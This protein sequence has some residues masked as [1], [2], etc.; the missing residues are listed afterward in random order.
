MCKPASIVDDRQFGQFCNRTCIW[1]QIIFVC[2]IV[3]SRFVNFSATCMSTCQ[4]SRL[5]RKIR[6]QMDGVNW[7]RTHFHD[8]YLNKWTSYKSTK[9]SDKST[10]LSDKS[11]KRSDKST[12]LSGKWGTEIC[13]HRYD[14]KTGSPVSRHVKEPLVLKGKI[15][16]KHRYKF[17][18]LHRLWLRPS[19]KVLVLDDQSVKNMQTSTHQWKTRFMTRSQGGVSIWCWHSIPTLDLFTFIR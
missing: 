15:S 17:A 7:A 16:A 19:M 4:I 12:L 14:L 10:K 2:L 11:T 3:L 1:S 5:V 8:E 18:A 6:Y 9:R 13:H